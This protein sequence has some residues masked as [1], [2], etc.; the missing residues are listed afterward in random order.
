VNTNMSFEKSFGDAVRRF[1]NSFYLPNLSIINGPVWLG[2]QLNSVLSIV[3]RK[4][5]E[6]GTK[7]T[8]V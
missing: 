4:S 7:Y 1:K 8:I 6:K 3:A 2:F 5:K